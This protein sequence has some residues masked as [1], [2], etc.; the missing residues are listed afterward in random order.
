[1]RLIHFSD[2]VKWPDGFFL[3]EMIAQYPSHVLQI[4]ID[5][6][7]FRQ[8]NEGI[9]CKILNYRQLGLPGTDRSWPSVIPGNQLVQSIVSDQYSSLPAPIRKCLSR[10]YQL[11]A[12][13]KIRRV[14]SI[15]IHTGTGGHRGE[16]VGYDDKLISSVLINALGDLLR[17]VKWIDPRNGM[18]RRSILVEFVMRMQIGSLRSLIVNSMALQ[19]E[20]SS[21]EDNKRGLFR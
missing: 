15:G 1:M 19:M 9:G 16:M 4:W 10:R 21:S 7:E 8:L 5:T 14:R 17:T 13:A 2:I 6:W 12:S 11:D 18:K 3:F 20:K